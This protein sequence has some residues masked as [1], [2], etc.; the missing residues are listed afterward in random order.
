MQCM[1]KKKH[2]HEVQRYSNTRVLNLVLECTRVYIWYR[3]DFE[4]RMNE[5]IPGL[6][7]KRFSGQGRM[8]PSGKI[9]YDHVAKSN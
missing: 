6:L 8:L 5:R 7:E 4:F 2:A 9:A 3:L 1:K